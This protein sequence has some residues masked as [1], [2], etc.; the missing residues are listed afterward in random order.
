[1][2]WRQTFKTNAGRLHHL[3][4]YGAI[5]PPRFYVFEDQQLVFIDN[6]KVASTSVKKALF[7]DLK[8]DALGQEPF[9]RLLEGRAALH[10]PKRA[11]KYRY[12]TIV[13]NPFSRLVSTYRD[14][15]EG[16][17]AEDWGVFNVKFYRLVFQHVGKLQRDQAAVS[18]NDFAMAVSRIPDW[19]S[20]RHIA[21]QTRWKNRIG[22]SANVNLLK[23]ET[24]S[25]D[26]EL[27]RQSHDL[28]ALDVLNRTP[29]ADWRPYYRDQAVID[30][31]S[32]R[33]HSD[34]EAF[35]YPIPEPARALCES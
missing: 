10:V 30:A 27:L 2:S 13:R 21:S 20:D 4:L 8:Y 35:D 6:P 32:H 7:R 9:H 14:K 31:V 11:L 5:D 16:R 23:F 1:M 33:Y 12:F 18:F 19:L 26:W 28:P 17:P 29:E 24:L 3:F 34:I 22:P 15:V 25:E